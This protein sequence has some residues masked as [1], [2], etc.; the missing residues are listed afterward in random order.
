M[1]KKWKV[2]LLVFF[3]LVLVLI[4]VGALLKMKNRKQSPQDTITFNKNGLTLKTVYCRPYKKG[5]V[6]FGKKEDGAIQPYGEYWRMGANEATTFK[7]NK[8]ILFAGESL[9][10]GEYSIYAIPGEKTWQIRL[11]SVND[12]WGV[13]PPDKVNDVLVVNLPV[14]YTDTIEEQFT[15]AYVAIDGGVELI[16]RWENSIVRIPIE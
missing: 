10:A 6:I 2:V 7:V 12:R 9:A 11:N 8:D 5:R 15:M 1:T 14:T 16:I 4:T 3:S 13:S